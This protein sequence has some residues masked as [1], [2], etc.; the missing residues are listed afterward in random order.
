MQ[1]CDARKILRSTVLNPFWNSPTN[2]S[3]LCHAIPIHTPAPHCDTNFS[4][5]F[6]NLSLFPDL[7]SMLVIDTG[8]AGIIELL[9]SRGFCLDSYFDDTETLLN[10]L[11]QKN[12]LHYVRWW[13]DINSSLS[14][15]LAHIHP[16]YVTYSL[17]IRRCGSQHHLMSS[18]SFCLT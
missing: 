17:V 7:D 18:R 4:W 16:Y 12:P 2:F 14:A 13:L 6:S 5:N 11:T 8:H 1:H 15:H 10:L 9:L 3:D